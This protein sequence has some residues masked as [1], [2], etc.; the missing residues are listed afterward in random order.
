MK[1]EVKRFG[2][3]GLLFIGLLLVL[4]GCGS[5]GAS[6]TEGPLAQS[7]EERWVEVLEVNPRP[8]VSTLTAIGTLRTPEQVVLSPKKAGI[9]KRI[10]VREGDPVRKGQILVELDDVDARLQL[11][12]AEARL[13]EAEAALVTSQT[14]LARYQR[15]LESKVISQQT[16]DDLL[17][18]V[19]LDEARLDLARA[20]LHLARQNLSD[21]QLLSPIDGVVNLKL[22]AT[23]EHVNVAPKDEILRIVQMDPLELEF[24]I[25]EDWVGRI[26]AGARITFSV[27]PLPAE[28]HFALLQMI[29]PTADPATRNVR[30]KAIVSNPQFRLK[31]GFSAEV[32][33]PAGKPVEGILIP[34]SALLS[35]EGKPYV[36]VVEDG[37]AHRREVAIGM[38]ADGQAEIS[39]GLKPGERVVVAGHEQLR[40]GLKVNLGR[41]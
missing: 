8:I 40:E 1:P 37:V 13:R 2:A 14:T 12:R 22:A 19:K 16:F 29:S 28:R 11:E 41:K 9:I 7:V 25:P 32:T 26:Q 10:F 3:R 39:K 5:K 36:Y 15:L 33:I 18:R 24:H 31:P 30:V 21:H 34:E 20:E 4:A 38:R 17:L 27:K 35:H 23:G 6:K